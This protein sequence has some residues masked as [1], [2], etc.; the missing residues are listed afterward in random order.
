MTYRLVSPFRRA[1]SA[2]ARR[3]RRG[4]SHQIDCES[5]ETAH[6]SGTL[7]LAMIAELGRQRGGGADRLPRANSHAR[8]SGGPHSAYGKREPEIPHPHVTGRP[9]TPAGG[10]H[11]QSGSQ[12]VGTTEGADPPGGQPNRCLDGPLT[13]EA[14]SPTRTRTSN[15]AVNSRPLYR[16]SYRGPPVVSLRESCVPGNPRPPSSGREAH[17]PPRTRSPRRHAECDRE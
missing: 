10:A 13:A 17:P 3:E 12:R 5:L 6:Q 7:A 9:T 2:A 11:R 15:L 14:G 4:T 1:A 8:R 16:L